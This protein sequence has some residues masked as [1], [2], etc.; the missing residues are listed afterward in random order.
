MPTDPNPEFYINGQPI[1]ASVPVAAGDPVVCE[2]VD[3]N[4]VSPVMWSVVSTDDSTARTDYSFVQSG[5]VGQT[6]TGSALT[7][8][9]AGVIECMVAGRSDLIARGKF[10][11]P[12]VGQE[13]FTDLEQ[14]EA[15]N[16]SNARSGMI[17][18]LNEHV[19]DGGLQILTGEV[20]VGGTVDFWVSPMA[21]DSTL[22]VRCRFNAWDTTSKESAYYEIYAAWKRAGAAA[23]VSITPGRIDE[24]VFE[25]DASWAFFANVTSNSARLQFVGDAANVVKYKARIEPAYFIPS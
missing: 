6:Y 5:T 23:P 12:I 13:V 25:E 7:D 1:T 4:G 10:Y 9:T 21:E 18:P 22:G 14:N 19:R 17:A 8:G 24:I 11:V 2:I 16:V 3:V 20:A 15:N